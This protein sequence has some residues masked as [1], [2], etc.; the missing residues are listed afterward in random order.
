MPWALDLGLRVSIVRDGTGSATVRLAGEIDIISVEAVRRA[1]AELVRTQETPSWWIPPLGCCGSSPSMDS[2]ASSWISSRSSMMRSQP[3]APPWRQA[4]RPG[5][6]AMISVHYHQ[7]TA[8]TE[9]QRQ[10]LAAAAAVTGRLLSTLRQA[11]GA[12][13]LPKCPCGTLRIPGEGPGQSWGVRGGSVDLH[14]DVSP[15]KRR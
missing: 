3:A 4:S 11:P 10:Q 14:P 5:L 2:S 12:T 13:G 7:P 8:W 9:R 1:V 15:L 6:I